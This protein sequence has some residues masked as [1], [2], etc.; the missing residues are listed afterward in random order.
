MLALSA[1]LFGA[2]A[3]TTKLATARLGG[4]QVAMVRFLIGLAPILLIPAIRRQSFTVQR[5]DL[6]F[7]RGFFGGTAVLLYFLA[8]EH[9]PV[10]VATLL[11]Y[12]APIF[13]G[14]FA[15][16]FIGE[17]VRPAVLIPLTISFTGIVLV[18]RSH[19]TG[20]EMLGFGRWELA[21][22]CSAMLSGVAVTAIR[23]A[24]RTESSWSIFASFSIFGLLATAPFGMQNWIDPNG[25]EWTMLAFVG[26]FSI[27]A[28]LLM[29]SAL[30]WV[31]TL[32]AGVISQLAVVVSMILG[33]VWLGEHLLPMTLI[34]SALTIIG[35]VA[36]MAITSRPRS[37][38]F[39]EAA[40]Q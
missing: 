18:V 12:T 32:S 17:R 8:I 10:G 26:L 40:E 38:A 37:S 4:A 24:R 6:L 33:A 9:I 34:G 36:V 5:W 30:R 35:V 11:N 22:L 27:S 2:M 39:D 14:V 31:E 21:G 3:F 25:V 29:T 15:A 7:Y 1:A 16:I 23:L 28:Q 13:S 20:G 19:A